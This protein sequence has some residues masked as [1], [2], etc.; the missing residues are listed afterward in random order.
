MELSKCIEVIKSGGKDS[1]FAE[2]YGSDEKTLQRQKERYVSALNAFSEIF[3]GR[4]DVCVFSAPGRTEIGGN[5][6][7]HQR[8]VVLAGA[9]KKSDWGEHR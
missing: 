5:H 3:P 9:V 7:D 4:S 8:G 2:L 6:T 1:L